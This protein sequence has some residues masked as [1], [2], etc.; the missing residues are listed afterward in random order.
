LERKKLETAVHRVDKAVKTY[1]VRG[2]PRGAAITGQPPIQRIEVAPLRPKILDRRAHKYDCMPKARTGIP[3]YEQAYYNVKIVHNVD[4]ALK[5]MHQ[6]SWD[7]CM[8]GDKN[9]T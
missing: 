4:L 1:K 7:A 5:Y 8:Y 3:I 2:G 6:L 9:L